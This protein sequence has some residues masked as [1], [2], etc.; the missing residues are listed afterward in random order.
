MSVYYAPGKASKAIQNKI[1]MS[2]CGMCK[3]TKLG[4]QLHQKQHLPNM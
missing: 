3:S 1:I 4:T 2:F